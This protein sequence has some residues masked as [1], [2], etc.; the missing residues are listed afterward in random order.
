MQKN[1]ET[2][3]KFDYF[4]DP[5]FGEVSGVRHKNSLDETTERTERTYFMD[6]SKKVLDSPIKP[7]SVLRKIFSPGVVKKDL[8]NNTFV[9]E[10]PDLLQKR[11]PLYQRSDDPTMHHF[12]DSLF[13]KSTFT[14]SESN[15]SKMYT[16]QI[17]FGRNKQKIMYK[18]NNRFDRKLYSPLNKGLGKKPLPSVRNRR[19]EHSSTPKISVQKLI[20]IFSPEFEVQSK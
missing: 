9:K 15:I 13:G 19:F 16:E 10:K 8:Q 14:S 5:I 7:V 12:P 6:E 3:T 20:K 17:I 2:K 1:K 18:K 4:I 11:P